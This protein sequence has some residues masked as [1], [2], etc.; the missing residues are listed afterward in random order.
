VIRSAPSPR[1]A[2]T[3]A[4]ASL[5][6]VVPTTERG[7]TASHEASVFVRVY[8]GGKKPVRALAVE[9]LLTNEGGEETTIRTDRLEAAEFGAQRAADYTVALPLER[10]APGSYLLTVSADAGGAASARG[11]VRFSVR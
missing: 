11:H 2:P 10:L 8:Q 3:G 5:I 6:P 9:A 4:L 1:V 7:F